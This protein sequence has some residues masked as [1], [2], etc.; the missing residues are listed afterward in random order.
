MK[1]KSI[2][3]AFLVIV[4]LVAGTVFAVSADESNGQSGTGT[5][6]KSYEAYYCTDEYGWRV[7][8]YVSKYI[9]LENDEYKKKSLKEDY[10]SIGYTN[11]IRGNITVDATFWFGGENK[12]GY[13]NM[14]EVDLISLPH[15]H[16]L[17]AIPA[18]PIV[19]DGGNI[20][21][22][23]SYFLSNKTILYVLNYLA[24]EKDFDSS[25]DLVKDLYFFHRYDVAGETK[26]EAK[27]GEEWGEQYILP[28]D[29][30]TNYVPWVI[31]YEPMICVYLAN[32]AGAAFLTA[33]E[34]ALAQGNSYN[35]LTVGSD[36]SWVSKFGEVSYWTGML[37]PQCVQSLVFKNLPK[38][39]TL[40]ESWFGYDPPPDDIGEVW[41]LAYIK[42]YGGWGMGFLSP[43][44]QAENKFLGGYEWNPDTPRKG[45]DTPEPETTKKVTL[46]LEACAPNSSYTCG[47]EVVTG[48]SV[49]NETAQDIFYEDY[50]VLEYK[51]SD[52]SNQN[53]ITT[54]RSDPIEVPAEN[55][56]IVWFRWTMPAGVYSVD[57]E[58]ELVSEPTVVE[59]DNLSARFTNSAK[60]TLTSHTAEPKFSD[61]KPGYFPAVQ[62]SK[63]SPTLSW[64]TWTYSEETGFVRNDYSVTMS[65]S[66]TISPDP[67][68]R[69]T[70]NVNGGWVMRSGYGVLV[71]ANVSLTWSDG[72][73]VTGYSGIT[74]A[75]NAS[76]IFPEFM[77]DGSVGSFE[78]AV[79][80][81]GSFVFPSNPD[82]QGDRI[83]YIPLWYP[84]GMENYYVG[85][86]VSGCWTPVGMLTA[87]GFSNGISINGS[88]YDDWYITSAR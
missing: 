34:F 25:F 33:T 67:D 59:G 56:T 20:D 69:S 74:A 68:I 64:H 3:S 53:I 49:T 87:R 76:F 55:D 75:Q 39:V 16:Y 52:S 35:W 83:H 14:S 85:V 58:A 8:L 18:P 15:F 38:S 19:C 46:S 26:W 61:K 62:P 24:E 47:E 13:S 45:D 31:I 2:I 7:S 17:D 72:T 65:V 88:L 71:N 28:L 32:G 11:L 80:S 82:A 42:F 43:A 54:G 23:N 84:D 50:I 12:I 66:A 9:G 63:L 36:E 29:S 79:L 73:A 5:I 40:N 51:V 44:K 81:D 37:K 22:V 4:I 6:N 57:I 21:T 30:R 41:D 77:W 70:K 86:T 48:Y 78:N 60:N 27:T 1:E 10:Y